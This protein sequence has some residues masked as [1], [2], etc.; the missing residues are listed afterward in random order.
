M[1]IKTMMSYHLTSVRLAIVKK[2]KTGVGSKGVEKWE[3][4]TLLV[5]MQNGTA[6]MENSIT[7]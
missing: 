3:P 4:L 6:T 2:T 5:G 7:I 1:Q